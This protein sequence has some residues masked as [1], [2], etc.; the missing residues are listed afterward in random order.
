MHGETVKNKRYILIKNASGG[1]WI[2]VF[3][4]RIDN[5]LFFTE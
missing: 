3:C 5:V 4:M 2:F 1:Q